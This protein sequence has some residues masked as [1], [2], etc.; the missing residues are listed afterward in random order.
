[1]F[2]K[3]LVCAAAALG[4]AATASA[5]V[6]IC[7]QTSR[8]LTVAMAAVVDVPYNAWSVEG[9]WNLRPG[10]CAT[11]FVGDYSNEKVYYYAQFL[12]NGADW[13]TN[14]NIAPVCVP[15]SGREF[16]RRG[17][18]SF[19]QSC[20]SGWVLKPFYETYSRVPHRQINL[21]D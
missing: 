8:S 9:W 20:P 5:D 15:A 7:N 12:D 6:R 18:A 2:K 19:V 11:P 17:T 4:L 3:A 16:T 10:Q 13:E 21:I 1:M 14:G